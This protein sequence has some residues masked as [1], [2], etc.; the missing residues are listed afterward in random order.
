MNSAV[1]L[2]AVIEVASGEYGDLNPVLFEAVQGGLCSDEGK[3]NSIDKNDPT[4]SCPSQCY[5]VS[6]EHTLSHTISVHQ[7]LTRTPL[8]LCYCVFVQDSGYIEK[9]TF[10]T[11]TL[12]QFCILFKRTFI[13]I[14]RDTVRTTLS[15]YC[16]CLMLKNKATTKAM[17]V[18]V[19]S[20]FNPPEGDVTPMYWCADWSA[21]LEHW[22]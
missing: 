7:S 17:S 6:N 16:L 21:V 15:C 19:C 22:E 4:T 13:T 1:F 5:N 12:T 8:M 11:S 9:H 14:C 20:G 18:C 10:A 2:L 3:K